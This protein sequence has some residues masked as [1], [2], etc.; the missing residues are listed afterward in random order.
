MALGQTQPL[1][2]MSTRNLP[3][4]KGWPAGVGLITSP[5]SV[6]R[7][8]RTRRRLDVYGSTRSVSGIGFRNFGIVKAQNKPCTKHIC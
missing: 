4:G 7:L 6:N 2:E 1:T 8:Y 3:G 5:P